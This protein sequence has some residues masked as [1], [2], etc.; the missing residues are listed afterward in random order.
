MKSFNT[1]C[2][3]RGTE[4]VFSHQGRSQGWIWLGL[5]AV[6]ALIMMFGLWYG[7]YPISWQNIMQTLFTSSL[8]D[9]TAQVINTI[10]L[11][12]R[13]SRLF[14]ASLVGV[15]LATSGA[16]FQGLLRNPLADPFTLGVSTGA[17]FGATVALILGLGSHAGYFGLGLLPFVAMLGAFAALVVVLNLAQVEGALRPATMIL[18][19]IVVSTFLSALISLLKS[20]DEESLSAIVFWMLGSFAGRGW[21]HVLFALPY[22]A[23]GLVVFLFYAHELDI[24]SM[25]ELEARHLGVPVDKVRMILLVSACLTTAAAVSISGVIGFVG[26]VIPHLI[27]ML[28]GPNH[29]PLL[30]SSALLGAITMVISDLLAKNIL[31]GGEELPVGVLTTLIGGPFFCYILKIRKS[32]I[33]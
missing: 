4:K 3:S 6:Y 16:V 13:L 20:L 8:Q 21:P 2:P 19:G 7:R 25:G 28:Q 27:R 5:I 11:D 29:R 26:L 14:L 22:V 18:A 31:S 24:L 15:A 33:A 17:A 23:I 9:E 12:V 10:V 30:V 1:H 32:Q